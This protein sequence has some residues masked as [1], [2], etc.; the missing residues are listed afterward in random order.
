MECLSFVIRGEFARAGAR[1]AQRR[2]VVTA[3][4]LRVRLPGISSAFA[5][6]ACSSGQIV[7]APDAEPAAFDFGEGD[8]ACR[9]AFLWRSGDSLE[10][11]P[12]S[13]YRD[14]RAC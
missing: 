9:A 6:L 7:A 3:S 14:V 10:I 8:V 2:T 12:H 4:R 5:W 11:D 1:R 13:Q